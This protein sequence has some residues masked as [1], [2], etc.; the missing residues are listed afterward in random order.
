MKYYQRSLSAREAD[1]C[2]NAREPKCVCRCKGAAHGRGSVNLGDSGEMAKDALATLHKAFEA[3]AAE[4]P[5][6][7]PSAIEERLIR[8]DRR[9]HRRYH[10]VAWQGTLFRVGKWNTP[11]DY[12][13][14]NIACYICVAEGKPT[15]DEWKAKQPPIEVEA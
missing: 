1:R 12:V 8:D 7:L 2:E 4:D 15:L 11:N 3:L 14:A 10:N 6:H 5:H 9:S 13:S